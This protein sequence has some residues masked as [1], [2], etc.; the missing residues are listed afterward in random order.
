MAFVCDVINT[1]VYTQ[2]ESAQMGS[3]GKVWHMVH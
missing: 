3:Q 1:R 2:F